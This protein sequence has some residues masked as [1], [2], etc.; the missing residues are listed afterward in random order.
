MLAGTTS[1]NPGQSR[2]IDLFLRGDATFDATANRVALGAG[3][4]VNRVTV[5]SPTRLVASVSVATTAALGT[6]ASGC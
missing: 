6:A 3:I 2:D 1:L 5:A 4:T